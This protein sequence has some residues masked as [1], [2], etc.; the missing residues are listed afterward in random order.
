MKFKIRI[1]NLFFFFVLLSPLYSTAKVNIGAGTSSFTS[2]RAVPS[3]NLGIETDSKWSA[4][5]QS[6]GVQT[7]VYSQNAWTLAGYK[8]VHENKSEFLGASIGAG[9]GATYIVRAYRTSPTATTDK[10]TESVVGPY[11]SARFNAGVFFIG[12]NTLLGL[13]SEVQQ[14]ILLNFQEVSHITIGVSL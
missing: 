7:T 2:G 12:F 10:L 9:L 6:E 1:R 3:L 4:E 8:V 5:F 13:T 11:L 14:H